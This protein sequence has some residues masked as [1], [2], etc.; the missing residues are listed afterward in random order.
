MAGEIPFWKG[1]DAKLIFSFLEDKLIVDH[2]DFEVTREGE[3][4]ADPVCGEDRD[5]LDFVTTHYDVV[6]NAMQQKT[7]Q[8]KAFIKEQKAKDARTLPKGSSVGILIFPNDGTVAAFQCRGYVLGKW[9]F[10][11]GGRKERNKLA[12]PGRCQYFDDLPTV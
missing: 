2:V 12:I 6:F 10:G 3:E 4:I 1:K 9:K 11:Y 5:R 7:D 8:I